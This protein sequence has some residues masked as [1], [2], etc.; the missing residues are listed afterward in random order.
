MDSDWP[1]NSLCQHFPSLPWIAEPEDQLVSAV[2]A[3]T[4][5][6][7]ACPVTEQCAR[8]VVEAEIVSGFWAGRDRTP[9]SVDRSHG[10]VA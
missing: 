5:V 10:G 1:A 7:L 9:T 4:V 8:Y 3:M 2:R 6:C